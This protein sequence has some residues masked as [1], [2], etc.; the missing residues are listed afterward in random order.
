MNLFASF[1]YFAVYQ[2]R[3]LLCSCLV[4]QFKIQIDFAILVESVRLKQRL[5][6]MVIKFYEVPDEVIV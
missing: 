4:V 2:I 5:L 6:I 3:S 1:A